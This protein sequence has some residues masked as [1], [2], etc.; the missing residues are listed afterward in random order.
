MPTDARDEA[1]WRDLRCHFK[2]DDSLRFFNKCT[3][4]PTSNPVLRAHKSA[5][6]QIAMDSSDPFLTKRIE[7]V[8]QQF[9]SFV[10][11]DAD[12]LFFTHSTTEGVNTF[13]H[14]IDWKPDD[15]VIL[16]REDKSSSASSLTATGNRRAS[17]H[18][19][20]ILLPQVSFRL[21]PCGGLQ[22]VSLNN[23]HE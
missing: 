5:D 9:A 23:N 12:E 1:Y 17:Q 7:D 14:G 11:A 13:A 8:R 16:A 10:H 3:A 4:A 20:A 22:K 6:H 21:R 19:S 18:T 15:E 2:L